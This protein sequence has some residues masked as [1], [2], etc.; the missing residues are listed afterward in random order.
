[1]KRTL[2]QILLVAAALCAGGET[3]LR[4]EGGVERRSEL[5][6]NDL[7]AEI[8]V[9]LRERMVEAGWLPYVPAVKPAD[10][11]CSTYVRTLVATNGAWRE[12]WVEASVPVPLDRAALVGAVLALPD[13]T[14]L[15]A[16]A[17]ASEP[18]A[19]WFA[20]EPTY[21]RGSVGARTVA[22]A[23]GVDAATLEALVAA[24]LGIAP[25]TED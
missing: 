25:A 19:A 21:V 20:E 3:F 14:N 16:A 5:S 7:P 8:A 18:V 10:T 13:G 24:S 9:P 1:M 15:L 23:L 22:A 11:W 12:G 6:T 4:V 2:L 17:M